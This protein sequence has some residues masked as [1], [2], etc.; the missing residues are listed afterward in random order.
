MKADSIAIVDCHALFL[1]AQPHPY[2]ILWQPSPGFEALVG[3]YSSL[4]R[5]RAAL[6]PSTLLPVIT[7]VS[8]T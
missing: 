8:S 3:E 2:P 4:H 7:R 6:F 1:D 5:C